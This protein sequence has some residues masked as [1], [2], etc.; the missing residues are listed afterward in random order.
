MTEG[1]KEQL[2]KQVPLGG[3]SHLSSG[4]VRGEKPSVASY[5]KVKYRRGRGRGRGVKRKELSK[6]EKRLLL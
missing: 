3:V 1:D 6:A 2:E 5:L 4:A